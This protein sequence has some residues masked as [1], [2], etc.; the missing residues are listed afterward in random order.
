MSTRNHPGGKRRLVHGAVSR[1]SRKCGSLNIS[2]PY[3]PS[4]PAT[5]IALHF[6]YL[7][8]YDNYISAYNNFNE[9]ILLTYSSEYVGVE[10][11]TAVSA[12]HL[13]SHWFLAQLIF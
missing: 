9:T 10:V 6:F 7:N 3:G 12:C 5:G 13:L 2:P 8:I 4:W 1:L 11:L